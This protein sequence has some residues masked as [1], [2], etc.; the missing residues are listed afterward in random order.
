MVQQWPPLQRTAVPA[1]EGEEDDGTTGINVEE[2]R[3]RLRREDLEFDKLEHR[4]KVK[5]KHREKRLKEKAARREASKQ[6]TEEQK[7]EEE[8]VAYLD[9]ADGEEFDPSTLPDPDKLCSFLCSEED[10]DQSSH[11]AGMRK[12]S[13]SDCSDDSGEED[14]VEGSRKRPRQQA[15]AKPLDTGLSLAEDEELVLHLLG[16]RR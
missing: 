5:E 11:A 12:R 13:L 7:S 14:E 8:V 3:E 9:G 2:A 6:H 4:R 1:T 16:N 15:A 10:D